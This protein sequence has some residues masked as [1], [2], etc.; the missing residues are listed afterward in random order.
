MRW[1]TTRT[2]R[3]PHAALTGALTVVRALIDTNDERPIEI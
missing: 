1:R 3:R 2:T